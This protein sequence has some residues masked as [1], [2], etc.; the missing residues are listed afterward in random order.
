VLTPKKGIG[1]VWAVGTLFFLVF[2]IYGTH[3][4]MEKKKKQ[5]PLPQHFIVE[6]SWK[7]ETLQTGGRHA[8]TWCNQTYMNFFRKWSDK[9]IESEK[10]HKKF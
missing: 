4:G 7:T 3:K 1:N 8:N 6:N 2:S 9:T 5:S 10:F